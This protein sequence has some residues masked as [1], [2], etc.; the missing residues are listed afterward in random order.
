MLEN[1]VFQTGA[2]VQTLCFKVSLTDRNDI[3]QGESASMAFSP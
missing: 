3:N 2:E 1:P